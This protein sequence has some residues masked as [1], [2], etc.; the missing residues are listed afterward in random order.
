MLLKAHLASHSRMSGCR[1]VT[2][3]LSGLLRAFLY[4]SSV[5]F[6]HRFLISSASVTSLIFS[7]I[8]PIFAR[9]ICL[10]SPIILKRSLVF[11]ILLCP[12]ISLHCSLEKTCLSLLAILWNSAFSWVY[13]SFSPL[14]FTSLLFSAIFK[15][16]SD[17]HFD[18]LHLMLLG[19][20]LVTTSYK[21]LWI[22]IHSSSGTLSSRSSPLNLGVNSTHIIIR[23]L[24]EII[25]EWLSSFS[26]FL[27]FE[28]E[29]CNKK[30]VI[31]ATVSSLCC[32]LYRAS[33]SSAAKNI[34]NLIL[35]LTI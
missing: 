6:Y 3:W 1:W 32:W 26:C 23:N 16:S 11:P 13:L 31:W 9:N 8:M 4:S 24:I 27:Q 12:S 7:F 30:F 34:I 14:P 28:P 19:M 10:V 20:V 22:S 5:Y 29:F 21:M 33:P 17:N 18:F 2:Q 15:A 25:P 35:V